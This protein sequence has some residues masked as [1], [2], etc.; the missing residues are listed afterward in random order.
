MAC[1]DYKVFLVGWSIPLYQYLFVYYAKSETCGWTG[2][3]ASLAVCVVG[4]VTPLTN[5]EYLARRPPHTA[6]LSMV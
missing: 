6:V 3:L 4:V 2:R 5:E 1:S